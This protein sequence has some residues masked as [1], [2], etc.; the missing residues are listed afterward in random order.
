MK[1]VYY[2]LAYATDGILSLES[3]ASPQSHLSYALK[4]LVDKYINSGEFQSQI[5]LFAR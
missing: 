5:T 2:L 4:D 1:G 3:R